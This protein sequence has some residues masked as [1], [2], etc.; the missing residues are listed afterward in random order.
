MATPK[1]GLSYIVSNQSQKEVTHNDAL[2]DLD[3]LAQI[4]VIDRTLATPP[5]SPADGDVYIVAGSP[6]GAWSGQA[7]KIAAYFAGW[8]FKTP[9]EGWVA[10]VQNEDA[11]IAYDGSSWGMFKHGAALGSNSAPGFFFSGDT[12]TG[13]YSPGADQVAVATNGTQRLTV[14][15][16]GST[17]VGMAALSTSA[18]DGFLYIP[19]CAGT[20]S[21][22]P[23][24]FTGRAP[25]VLDTTNNRLY[26]HNGSAW[27]YAALV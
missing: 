14:S 24:A 12:N 3:A 11:L 26:V 19:T 15:A 18:T 22:T 27:K 25:I 10:W 23:T 9:R 13:V 8:K 6:T 21:G 4:S 1:L 5:G 7:G 17:V 2:N 20:P 16:N